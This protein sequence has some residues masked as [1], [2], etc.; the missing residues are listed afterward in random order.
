MFDYRLALMTGVDL[1]IPELQLVSHQPT[2]KEIS[3]VGEYDFLIGVQILCLD[4]RLYVQDPEVLKQV[5]NFQIFIGLMNSA[6][7]VDKK[8]LVIQVLTLVFPNTKVAFTPRSMLLIQDGV[9]VTIDEGNFEILQSVLIQQFCIKNTDQDQF[10]PQSE[11]AREIAQKLMKGRQRVAA[12]R[13]Q[14]NSGSTFAQYLSI[15]AVAINGMSLKDALSLTIYQLYDLIER[16]HLYLNWDIDIRA[17]MAGANG[18]KPV[19][20]WMK[21]IH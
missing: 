5:T 19:E 14:E 15:I 16:Y 1:P 3:M 17:R 21:Q 8:E 9:N 2:I 10:N 11:K 13:A 7:M 20:N 12:Q 18:D 6:E 4:K